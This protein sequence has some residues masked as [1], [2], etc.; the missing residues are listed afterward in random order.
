VLHTASPT[1]TRSVATT[2]VYAIMQNNAAQTKFLPFLVWRATS[3]MIRV[4]HAL[5]VRAITPHSLTHS[6]YTH[7]IMTLVSSAGRFVIA[8]S[9]RAC[10]LVCCV[11]S[12]WCWAS[13]SLPSSA[14]WCTGPCAAASTCTTRRVVLSS[15]PSCP[16]SCPRPP[17]SYV[18][19]T[20]FR[21]QYHHVGRSLMGVRT[22][23][24]SCMD[25]FALV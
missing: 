9:I 15:P 22:L 18:P 12:C 21:N 2:R 17:P 4:N 3:Q 7:L 8:H 19:C 16:P 25:F 14:S 1:P 24:R 20:P 13:W 6:I 5:P 10:F 23:F 11:G